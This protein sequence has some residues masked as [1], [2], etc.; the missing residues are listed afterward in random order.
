MNK[1]VVAVAMSRNMTGTAIAAALLPLPSPWCVGLTHG[2]TRGCRK[3]KT[4]TYEGEEVADVVGELEL[5][6]LG[7]DVA[8]LASWKEV[9]ELNRMSSFPLFVIVTLCV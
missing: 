7:T 9:T 8:F 4:A 3:R 2:Q 6:L 5:V 1:K